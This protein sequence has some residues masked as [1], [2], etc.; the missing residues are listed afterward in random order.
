MPKALTGIV[1]N[2][3]GRLVA[4]SW[5]VG[6]SLVEEGTHL[7][8]LFRILVTC[9]QTVYIIYFNWLEESW[10]FQHS[11]VVAACGAQAAIFDVLIASRLIFFRFLFSKPEGVHTCQY[12]FGLHTLEALADCRR[13]RQN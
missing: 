10:W 5:E 6:G 2:A 8:Q 3:F 13:A 1:W 12:C 4:G 7:S 11:L 9:E